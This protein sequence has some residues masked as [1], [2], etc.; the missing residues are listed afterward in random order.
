[1]RRVG[2]AAACV[3][4]AGT[5]V[6]DVPRS[7]RQLDVGIHEGVPWPIINAPIDGPLPPEPTSNERPPAAT[8]AG[9]RVL[10]VIGDIRATLRDTR[11]QA[12]TAVR[13]AEGSYRWDCSGMATWILRR[14]A[15]VAWKALASSRPVARDFVTAIER[16]PTQRP[17][18]GWQRISRLDDVLPGDVFAWRRP[19][20]LP[21]KN[22]GHVGF[23]VERPL[24]V[25]GL[26]GGWAVRIVDSTS[27]YHQADDR[28]RGG[29]GG[30][31]TGTLVFLVDGDGRAT[32]Y[33]WSGTQSEWYIVTPIVFGRVAR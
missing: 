3:L 20:G 4:M 28:A 19:R 8:P 15:P 31:G 26:P 12:A 32:S 16:A 7:Q 17:R 22:T 14:A 33:G 30:F 18:S 11:Y 13:V 29:G 24:P 25:P 23:V 21:S 27:S 5:A 10:A 2:V 6:A 1:M 9:R